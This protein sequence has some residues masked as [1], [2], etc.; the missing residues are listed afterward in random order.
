MSIDR[1]ESASSFVASSILGVI[2][3][4]LAVPNGAWALDPENYPKADTTLG[5][6]IGPTEIDD[7]Q[8]LSDNLKDKIR[9][10]YINGLA[11]R[12]AHPKAHGCVQAEFK[13]RSDLPASLSVGLFSPGATY[14]AVIRFSNGS[15]NAAG[16]DHNGDTRGMATKLYGVEGKKFFDDPGAPDAHDF[17]QISS[18]YFFVNDSRGYTDFFE[19]VNSGQTSQLFKIPFILGWKGTVNAAKMLRQ[20]ISNPLDVT[21]YS[22]T[23]YQFGE[24]DGRR[25][26]KYSAIPCSDPVTDE[27]MHGPN[28]LRH[29]MQERLSKTSACFD[30]R[31]QVR[32]DSTFDVEDVINAWDEV[33]APFVPVAR[34]TIPE[35]QFDT[36]ERNAACEAL[37]YNPWHA[38]KAHKPLGA[39]NR[40]RRV[41]YQA[42]SELRFDMN[43]TQ[44]ANLRKGQ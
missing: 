35:Q 41:V 18:P 28:F 44:A 3:C 43:G 13:V 37:T 29:A 38:I 36:P 32:P 22:V 14:D 21:Y 2:S 9:Q 15:P 11:R 27:T 20:K 12:D 10:D 34:I 4:I 39:I 25:A 42:I 16:D 31:I 33:K 19:R 8:A 1:L 40:M 24:G 5:E 23:P 6:V 30:F 7:A 17:I 26:V